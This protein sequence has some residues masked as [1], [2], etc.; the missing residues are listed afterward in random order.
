MIARLPLDR[1]PNTIAWPFAMPGLQPGP[2]CCQSEALLEAMD[3]LYHGLV[4]V[5]RSWAVADEVDAGQLWEESLQYGHNTPYEGVDG[6]RVVGL[7]IAAD[8]HVA[9][10]PHPIVLCRPLVDHHWVDGGLVRVK[11]HCPRLIL[12]LFPP[13]LGKVAL[14]CCFSCS[15]Q[16]CLQNLH[17]LEL[18]SDPVAVSFELRQVF[19][20]G[21]DEGFLRDGKVHQLGPLNL[22]L[23]LNSHPL[24]VVDS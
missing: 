4:T 5:L 21:G 17:L 10:R 6:S 22:I 24:P 12:E 20:K 9:L 2:R 11:V 7:A 19:H 14:D 13:V 3:Y 23:C 15:E 1:A 8:S 16:G 18:G